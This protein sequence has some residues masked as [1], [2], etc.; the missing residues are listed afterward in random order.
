[1]STLAKTY[2]LYSVKVGKVEGDPPIIL[3]PISHSTMNAQVEIRINLNGEFRGANIVP[4]GDELTVIPVTEDSAARGNGNFPH[5]LCDK[6]CYVAGDYSFYTGEKKVAYY[7]AYMKQL[8]SWIESEYTHPMLEAIYRYLKKSTVIKDLLEQ[9][10]L[11]LNEEKKLDK[12][13]KILKKAQADIS[14]RFQVLS[15]DCEEESAVWKNQTIYQKFIEFYNSTKK[16]KAL[17]YVTGE[18]G[19][20]AD[21]HPSKIRNSGDKSK[22]LSANDKS[23]FTYRGRFLTKNQAVSVSYDVSQ[24]AHAAL[25]WLLQRQG[26]TSDGCSIVCWTVNRDFDLPNVGEDSVHAYEKIKGIE[27]LEILKD[28]EK[29][30][31]D[32]NLYFERQFRNAVMGYTGR[33]KENDRVAV[34]ALDAATTGRLSITYYDEMGAK[35]YISSILNWQEHCKWKRYVRVNKDE[36]KGLCLENTP[37]L[38]EMSLAAFGVQRDNKYLEADS[39]LIKNTVSRLLPCIT[40]TGIK[41]PKDIIHAAVIRASNPQ[42]MD[43][44]V[45]KNDVLAVVCAMI[46]YNFEL[47]G[48]TMNTFLE[49]NTNDRSVL[50][51]RLL[52]I[53]DYKENRAMFEKDEN[54]KIVNQRVTN[55]KRYWNSFSRRPMATYKTIEESL[56]PYERKLSSYEQNYFQEQTRKVINLL[57]TMKKEVLN[58][59]LSEL[60]LLAYHQQMEIMEQNFMKKRVRKKAKEN[61]YERI[62]EQN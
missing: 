57:S 11:I 58:K 5:Q 36:K 15:D 39:K 10:I 52:A 37:S 35:Q 41:I 48:I 1:M 31:K 17:C 44:F 19:L 22:L 28:S 27:L 59:A 20:C 45:W 3:L 9:G 12:K 54:G 7:Q 47:G 26:Y 42:T 55:A 51:G 56:I 53:C 34:I 29:E 21:K 46:R 16:E 18:E 40:K 49:D 4:A 23:G 33:I 25:R 8:K 50:F 43:D 61:N 24:R 30:G 13:A 32:S 2:D 62:K 38:R 14:I 6:L 60:Y